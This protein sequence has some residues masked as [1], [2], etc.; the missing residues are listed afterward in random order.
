[1]PELPE[2]EITRQKLAPRLVGRTIAGVRTTAQSYFFL[3]RPKELVQKLVGKRI[4]TLE[5]RGKYLL[6]GL[7]DDS[8]VLLHLGMTGQ[9][10]LAGSQSVRLLSE[11]RKRDA[12]GASLSFEPDL[13]T[14]LQFEFTDGAPGLY[15]RD[16]RKFGKVRWIAPGQSDERLEKLGL[17]AL[18][19][20]GAYL[21]AHTRRRKAAIK[22]VL[23]D[24]SVLA[25]VGNIYADEALFLSGVRPGR[26][27]AR[28][29]KDECTALAANIRRVLLRSIE[30]GGSSISDFINPDG[31]DGQ[32]QTERRVY[33]RTGEGCS[34][35]GKAIKRIVIGARSSHYCPTCQ[36]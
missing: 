11:R 9:L 1:M 4:T 28:L 35:C 5:R 26:S 22:S 12:H 29:T 25:G 6:L 8:R 30:T 2:V 10:F 36:R 33:A 17:D 16:V 24:Q 20:D 21:F 19:V 13:H 27:A 7:D 34:V 18:E 14:H 32:F 3:T 15:F 31:S 23:L